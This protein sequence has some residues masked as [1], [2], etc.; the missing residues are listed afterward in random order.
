MP[1]PRPKR[2]PPRDSRP[3]P[4]TMPETKAQ[5]RK[6]ARAASSFREFSFSPKRGA[7]MSTTKTGAVYSRTAATD[8]EVSMMVLK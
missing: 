8:R 5:P 4:P 2:M 1:E 7:D 6:A 3:A